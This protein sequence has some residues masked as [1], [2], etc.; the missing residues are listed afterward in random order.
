MYDELVD[1]LNQVIE[2]K[3]SQVNTNLPGIVVDY[4]AKKNRARVRPVMPK[5][6]ADGEEL[7][8]PEIVEVPVVW[9]A[10]GAGKAAFTMPLA[11]GDEVMLAAQQ[12]SLENWLS[13]QNVSPDDPRQFDLSDC[14]AFPGMSATKTEGHSD[15]VVLKFG[16]A[17][18]TLKP[19]N[20]IVFGNDNGSITIHD[21]GD[22]EI[23]GNRIE[24]KSTTI[25]VQTSARS[26]VLETHIHTDVTSGPGTSGPPQ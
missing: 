16:R 17:N 12:R 23:K 7:A 4:D 15:D 6:L 24:L 3:L 18:V 26:F 25:P 13:G 8:A 9:P 10:S 11:K 1:V 22:I 20:T 5:R 14:V 19:D 21:N 2:A